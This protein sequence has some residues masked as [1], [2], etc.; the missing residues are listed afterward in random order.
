MIMGAPRRAPCNKRSTY[1]SNLQRFK[2]NIT[3]KLSLI[4]TLETLVKRIQNVTR[5]TTC[6][7]NLLELMFLWILNVN[8]ME[9]LYNNQAIEKSLKLYF[10]CRLILCLYWNV[11]DEFHLFLFIQ[12]RICSLQ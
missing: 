5:H 7:R 8:L 1:S 4:L 10:L 9:V 6:A 11:C 3:L 12:K 2:R